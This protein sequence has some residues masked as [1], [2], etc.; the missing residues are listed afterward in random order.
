MILFLLD[1]PLEAIDYDY[2]LSES[3]L[4]P[5]R[6]IRLKEIKEIGLTEEFAGTLKDWIRSIHQHLD[7]KYGGVK[8]YLY[9]IGID[10]GIQAKLVEIL[11]A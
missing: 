6:E 1:V 3:E 11:S 4:L 7:W 10:E 8:S 5:E 9:G 2:C